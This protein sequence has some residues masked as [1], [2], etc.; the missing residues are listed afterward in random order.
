MHGNGDSAALWTTTVWR[1]E[2]NGWPRDRLHAID[3]PDPGA[4]D[5]D[6]V[7]QA[8]RTST[9]EHAQY[10]SAEVDKVLA[11]TGARQVV[12]VG[13]SRGGYAIRNVR[14]QPRRRAEGVDGGAGRHAE[15]WC[16]GLPS[17]RPNNEFNGAG[18]FL[19]ALNAPQ[20]SDGDEVT[21]GIRWLTIRS[22]DNDKFAQPDGAWIGAKGTPTNVTPTGR[23]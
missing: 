5:D 1:F 14:A 19:K 23:R 4:R 18:P 6:T 9:A 10:L 3:L 17:F 22:D 15:P 12:L 20:G 13:N 11:R 2:S 16:M 8:G 7:P 21:A